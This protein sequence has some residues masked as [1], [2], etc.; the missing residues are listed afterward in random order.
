MGNVG[1]LL[2]G[3]ELFEEAEPD[4]G[5]LELIAITAKNRIEWARTMG[6]VALGSAGDSPFA[7]VTR[8]KRFEIRFK[9]P[10]LYQL[11]G[12]PRKTV[13]RLRVAVH[14]ASITVCMPAA[15]EPRKA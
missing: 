13:R 10:F 9:E 1:K 8:G 12:D 6:R 7:E 2:G 15:E 4:D 5:I 11:D 14:P 3:I